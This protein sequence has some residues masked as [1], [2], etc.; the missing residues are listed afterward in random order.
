MSG[1]LVQ[2]FLASIIQVLW[3]LSE[4]QKKFWKLAKFWRRHKLFFK[5]SPS[6][7]EHWNAIMCYYRYI[8]YAVHFRGT[9]SD[10]SKENFN[11]CNVWM[12]AQVWFLNKLPVGVA[13]QNPAYYDKCFRTFLNKKTL[14]IWLHCGFITCVFSTNWPCQQEIA[15]IYYFGFKTKNKEIT[16]HFKG[17]TTDNGISRMLKF[18]CFEKKEP[19]VKYQHTL[20]IWLISG[21]MNWVQLYINEK[22]L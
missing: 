18:F 21:H 5:R 6:W 10:Q 13:Y 17:Q 19:D 8:F 9:F 1:R 3:R 12:Y 20:L 14:L 7:V 2:C 11:F 4:F 16:M 22:K 15:L